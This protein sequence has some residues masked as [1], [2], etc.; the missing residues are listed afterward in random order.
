M[1]DL[2]VPQERL[3]AVNSQAVNPQGAFV[4]YWMTAYRRLSWNFALDRAVQWALELKKPLLI[5]E[6]LRLDYPWASDRF[7]AFVLQGMR[8]NEAL[9][10]ATPATYYAY[11]ERSIGEGKGLLSALGQMCCVVVTDDFPA[12]FL[13]SMI[14]AAG[15]KL[16][17]LLEKVDSNGLLPMMSPGKAFSSAYA[18]RRYLQHTLP[19]YLE[20]RPLENPLDLLPPL[21]STLDLDSLFSRWPPCTE[22]HLAH[23][24]DLVSTL[25]I[26]HQVGICATLGGSTPGRR[27]LEHFIARNLSRY[28]QDRNHPDEDATSGLSPYLHFGHVSAH[29]IFN[30]VCRHEAWTIE[31]LATKA[32]GSR[33]GWWGMNEGA[34][35]FL[36][37]LVTWRELGFNMCRYTTDNDAYESLPSWAQ[38]TLERHAADARPYVYSL[39]DFEKAETH[40]PLWNAAQRELLSEGRIHNYLRML[41]GKKILH[42][43]RT[44]QEALQFMIE[45]NNKY[46]LD[47]RDPNSYTGIFWVLGRY[48]R[49]WG[50]ERSVF[51]KVRYM[52]SKNTARKIHLED[53]LSTYGKT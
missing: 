17:V 2:F 36:D 45:L 41:W 23:P 12:F 51:G 22:K 4:L 50:P 42:W 18:F 39:K 43:T 19:N 8:E 30:A 53:Y 40:D 25:P 24:E 6:A 26:D 15:R 37:Q 32:T 16:P 20:Q 35:A 5:L 10:R 48:D 46:A 27:R 14:A 33:S 44:P 13:P 34:E 1:D 11:V 9:C 3:Q 49:P 29:E 7:H 47:G 31:K 52:S 21:Q 28:A 38:E